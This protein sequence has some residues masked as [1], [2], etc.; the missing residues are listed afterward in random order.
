MQLCLPPLCSAPLL[1]LENTGSSHHIPAPPP[2]RPAPRGLLLLRT[3]PFQPLPQFIMLH[4][5]VSFACLS[6]V[7]SPKSPSAQRQVLALFPEKAMA[8]HSTTL[9]WIIPW[10]E[11]PGRL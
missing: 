8:T 10:M 11:E 7:S 2:P 5:F 6:S 1:P 3:S 4:T 9:A